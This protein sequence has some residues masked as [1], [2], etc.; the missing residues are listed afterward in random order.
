M[1]LSRITGPTAFRPL[2]VITLVAIYVNV[3]SGALV[4][5]T[6]SGLGCPDW[7]LCNGKPT[8]PLQFHGLIEFTNRVFAL[9]VIIVAILL[10]EKGRVEDL[11]T[12]YPEDGHAAISPKLMR[13]LGVTDGFRHVVNTGRDGRQEVMH[14]HLHVMGGPRPWIH[15]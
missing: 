11:C 5:V 8:P 1:F 9:F 7:P 14:V 4:R 15:G 3:V 2:A 12:Q 6:N 10:A 13:D